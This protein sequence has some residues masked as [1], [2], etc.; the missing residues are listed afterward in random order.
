MVPMTCFVE[1]VNCC[2]SRGLLLLSS[3]INVEAIVVTL[4]RRSDSLILRFVNICS[5]LYSKCIS[6]HNFTWSVDN[7]TYIHRHKDVRVVIYKCR[8]VY[9]Q[10]WMMRVITVDLSSLIAIYQ[11]GRTYND[12]G[13]R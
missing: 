11:S 1:V 9:N 8:T 2:K 5:I 6:S 12:T 13:V 10:I 3:N 7:H 4:T